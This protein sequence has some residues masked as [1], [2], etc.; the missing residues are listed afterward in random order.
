MKSI[1]SKGRLKLGIVV[2]IVFFLVVF[3]AFLATLYTDWLWFKEVG[4]SQVF[5]RTILYKLA[6]FAAFF[7]FAVTVIFGN[8]LWARRNY[9]K[10]S[11]EPVIE[12]PIIVDDDEDEEAEGGPS[13]GKPFDYSNIFQFPS[14]RDFIK[15]GMFEAATGGKLGLIMF[16]VSLAVGLFLSQIA[17]TDSA[18]R[19]MLLFVNNTPFGVKDP[20]LQHDVSYY[21]GLIPFAQLVYSE[22]QVVL[23]AS[24]ILCALFYVMTGMMFD[25]VKRHSA[26]NHGT[27]LVA[28]FFIVFSA[29]Y[30]IKMAMLL[31]SATGV[32]YGPGFTDI[33]VTMQ[34]YKVAIFLSLL[35]AVLVIVARRKQNIKMLAA[36]P[37]LMI[38]AG[39]VSIVL[40][41]AMQ[42]FIVAP[43][44]IA[45]E[46][47]Y[48]KNNIY[49]TR[50]AYGLE[51]L[52]GREFSGDT[53]L[54]NQEIEASGNIINNIRV[55]DPR[56]SLTTYRQTQSIRTYYTFEDVD[57]DRYH[58]KDGYRQVFVSAREMAP[59]Q[60][61]SWINKHIKFTHGYGMVASPVNRVTREGQPAYLI[62]DIPPVSNDTLEITRP[63]IYFGEKTDYYIITGAN[64]K[65]LDYPQGDDNVEVT[66]AGDAGIKMTM[67]N[68]LAFAL[69]EQEL[70]ILISGELSAK[71]RI[72]INRNIKQ[73]VREL[74]PY[75]QYDEDPYMVIDDEGRL[76]WIVDA[77]TT[78]AYYPYSTPAAEGIN[79]IRNS[80]KVVIDA[81]NGTI[82]Y[83]IIDEK[84]PLVAAYAKA[85]PELYKK[86]ADMPA[87]LYAHV[88]YPIDLFKVQA[89]MLTT[90]HMVNP[91]V[92]Y[93]K[94]DQW[95]IP[96]EVYGSDQTQV[97]PYYAMFDF[98][99]GEEFTL[100][101]PLTPVNKN[102]MIAWLAARNDG[103]HYGEL[104]LYKFPKRKL[105]YGPM[106]IEARIN[107]DPVI[108]PQLTLWGQ[109]GNEVI[110]GNLF[111]IPINDSILYV[112]PLYLQATTGQGGTAIPEMRKVIVVYR[113]QVVMQNTLAEAL[114]VIF[115]GAD[116]PQSPIDEDGAATGEGDGTGEGQPPVGQTPKQL[117]DKANALF[118]EAQ[119][120]AGQGDWKGY[121][122]KMQQLQDVLRQLEAAPI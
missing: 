44:E 51:S 25:P 91:G 16:V 103:E 112:E 81:F 43:N 48:I 29:G 38:M 20:I 58:L 120:A 22:V 1:Q 61:Q 30:F 5:V 102:N 21:T 11:R 73:R 47:E 54:T 45:K 24:I 9:A 68:R 82:D 35:A 49:F 60:E 87:D 100:M 55:V 56:P 83:Y 39:V 67:L 121:G 111:V 101:L 28:A 4:Y 63:E 34:Y 115:A 107:Q 64:T 18:F 86:K 14:S 40:G 65:E 89:E 19:K 77:Y 10:H 114:S 26:I 96:N 8:L 110:R 72:I 37:V 90:Y 122:D 36:G 66:Y 95:S 23:V 104:F 109:Q 52:E 88:R 76:F 98:G 117:V 2:A 71:S 6:L 75:L 7:V 62:K 70:K 106:Q 32:V 80:V 3:T 97:Q 57:V 84:D 74:A 92:F 31:F 93:N 17:L 116:V 12:E 13:A 105:I 69:R 33:S 15:P 41:M 27:V 118:G 85:F 119:Q 99:E 79:Y 53:I 42:T 46:T 78:S 94:E 113:D 59:T 108:S 50:T